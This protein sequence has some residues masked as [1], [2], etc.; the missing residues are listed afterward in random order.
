MGTGTGRDPYDFIEGQSVIDGNMSFAIIG[1]K[2]DFSFGGQGD[3]HR[4]PTRIDLANKPALLEV[5]Y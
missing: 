3:I 5:D 4:T 1:D 2:E